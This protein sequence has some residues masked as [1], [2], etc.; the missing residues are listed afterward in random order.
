MKILQMLLYLFITIQQIDSTV[1]Q[2]IFSS[3]EYYPEIIRNAILGVES[4][5]PP[6]MERPVERVA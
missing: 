3:S 2:S 5:G 1:K 6:I 4:Q